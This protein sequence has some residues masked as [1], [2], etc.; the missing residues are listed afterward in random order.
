MWI[1]L[2]IEKLIDINLN[3]IIREFRKFDCKV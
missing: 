3:F 2:Q 1:Y